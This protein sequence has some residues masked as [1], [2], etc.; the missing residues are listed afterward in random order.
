[1]STLIG[2]Y[3][4]SPTLYITTQMQYQ[5]GIPGVSYNT[6]LRWIVDGRSNIYLVW[7]HGAVSETNGLGQPVIQQDN[8]VIFKVQCYFRG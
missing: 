5:N 1:M 4:F 6:R 7:N 2:A 8:E 3:S